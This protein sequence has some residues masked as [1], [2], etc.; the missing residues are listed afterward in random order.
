[1]LAPDGVIVKVFPTQMLPLLT[2]MIGAEFTVIVLIAAVVQPNAEEPV[3][4]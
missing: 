2:V 4:V 1:V 3:T